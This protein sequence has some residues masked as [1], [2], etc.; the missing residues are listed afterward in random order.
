MALVE[1][2]T[3]ALLGVVI[4]SR[5]ERDEATLARRLVPLLG[6]GMLLL[7][8]RAFDSGTFLRAVHASGAMLL[9]RGKSYRR[10]PVLAHLSEGSYRSRL[11]D[12]DVRII[13]AAR[14]AVDT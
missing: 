1:T 12:V 9:I 13:E 4:G 10:P 3:R 11:D 6:R 7:A 14:T 2:G 8:D 5:T